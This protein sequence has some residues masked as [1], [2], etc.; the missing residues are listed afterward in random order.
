MKGID[1]DEKYVNMFFIES[2]IPG[3]YKG[4]KLHDRSIILNAVIN[5]ANRDALIGAGKW[6]KNYASD[7]H[8]SY[9]VETL[10]DL[11][12]NDVELSSMVLIN[13]LL[14]NNKYDA[15]LGAIQK[16]VNM[17]L[18]YLYAL[19][20]YG[21]YA[22]F[23]IDPAKCDCPLDSRILEKINRT[24]IKWTKLTSLAIY[25]EVQETI[26]EYEDAKES[27]LFFDFYNW[28]G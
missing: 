4:L 1:M 18:K 19:Q 23:T 9:Y 15:N 3:I 21:Y 7:K 8:S 10:K 22:G 2:T 27:R 25:N 11:I 12:D 16:L 6:D 14:S 28:L 20:Y 13:D 24:D 5:K 26:D 17:T